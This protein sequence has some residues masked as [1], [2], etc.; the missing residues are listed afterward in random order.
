MRASMHVAGILMVAL[1]VAALVAPA[2]PT[3]AS[4]GGQRYVVVWSGQVLP[5]EF[6]GLMA[7]VGGRIVH[8]MDEIGVAVVESGDPAF[9]D[10]VAGI[11]GVQGVAPDRLVAVGVPAEEMPVLEGTG[12][13]PAGE[14]LSPEGV[15]PAE[16]RFFP[17]QWNMRAIGADRAWAA[18][19]LGD[20]RV[21]VAVIDS[22]IDFIHQDLRPRVD[23]ALSRAFFTE[24]LPPGAP[25]YLDVYGHGTHVAGIIAGSGYNVAGVAPRVTLIA[26]KVSGR[27]GFAQYGD[28]IAAITYAADVGADVINMSFGDVLVKQGRDDAQLMAALNRAMNYAHARGAL[29]V[30]SAG[31]SGI[32]WDRTANAMKIPAELPH[33]VAVS[34]TGPWFGA[35]P[36]AMAT[37]EVNGIG[38]VYTDHGMSIINFAAPG[39]SRTRYFVS[40]PGTDLPAG[41]LDMIISACA[42]ALRDCG[43][44]MAGLFAYGTSMAAAHVSGAAALVDSVYGGALTGDQIVAILKQT[45]D[46]LGKPGKDMWYGFGRINV[47]R[48]VTGK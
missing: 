29:L 45:A 9:A 6:E 2:P 44:G 40:P 47:Y 43:K 34:A 23:Q 25:P 24:P 8:R 26:V 33:V 21:K 35:N 15:S 39:G 31:N 41:P 11:A 7:S 22:G 28:I 16:A 32:N 4:A 46:D 27:T 12:G 30:A 13:G 10:A 38:F 36:D 5:P 1:S 14:A 37:V 48:A 20:P 42:R 17:A 3:A 18:G 19:V